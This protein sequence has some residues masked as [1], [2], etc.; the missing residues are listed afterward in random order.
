VKAHAVVLAVTTLVTPAWGSEAPRAVVALKARCLAERQTLIVELDGVAIEAKGS[1]LSLGRARLDDSSQ[2][3]TGGDAFALAAY[4]SPPGKSFLQCRS[5]ETIWAIVAASSGRGS[6]ARLWSLG[7]ALVEAW[8]G[9]TEPPE[10]VLLAALDLAARRQLP[11]WRDLALLAARHASP[12]VR[13]RAAELLVRGEGP[14]VAGTFWAL[15]HDGS[16]EVRR[17]SLRG[18]MGHCAADSSAL[19]AGLLAMF[20]DDP[21]VEVAWQ[22]RDAL[23]PR[24]PRAAL[25]NA[26]TAYKLDV[27]PLLT[28]LLDR[29]GPQAVA[30]PLRL[31]ADDNDA[32]VRAAALLVRGDS[33]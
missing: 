32:E 5:E 10:D 17:A 7:E 31:L 12:T 6:A 24:H 27:I 13:A 21:D 15:A 16:R 22:A 11:A 4:S 3:A 9:S 20:I 26:P 23:L 8:R 29:D 30:E 25:L 33:E 28:R 19:C 18:V 1:R 14:A 2:V